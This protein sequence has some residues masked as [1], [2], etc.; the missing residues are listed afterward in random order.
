MKKFPCASWTSR[1]LCP[2]GALVRHPGIGLASR[3]EAS[4][5][6]RLWRD[7]HGETRPLAFLVRSDRPR[8]RQPIH[9]SWYSAPARSFRARKSR[10][11]SSRFA[12]ICDNPRKRTRK[13]ARRSCPSASLTAPPPRLRHKVPKIQLPA[14]CSASSLPVNLFA[15]RSPPDRVQHVDHH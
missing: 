14:A 12:A 10:G 7:D 1:P 2:P 5:G 9:G 4:L 3:E 13:V 15:P 6:Q 8:W 11:P